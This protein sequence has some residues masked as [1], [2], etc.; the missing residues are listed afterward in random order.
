M[1]IAIVSNPQIKQ[2]KELGNIVLEDF[3]KKGIDS[4]LIDIDNLKLGY[5]FVLVIGGDGTV[6]K[7]ARFYSVTSTPIM[8]VNL[9]RLGFLSLVSR[10]SINQLADIIQNGEYNI[11][12]RIMLEYEGGSERIKAL[13]DFVIKGGSYNR[14]SKFNLFINEK[15]I[16]DCIADGL[17]ISTPTGSTA[18]GLSAGGPVLAPCLNCMVIVPI[19]A[20][21]MNVRPLV[22]PD[23]EKISVKSNNLILS[24]D[25]QECVSKLNDISI[26][27]SKHCA[28]LAFPKNEFFYSVLKS[29]LYWGV[30][31][32][33]E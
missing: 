6:L 7:T 21:T 20:H 12:E 29:K 4:E 26:V 13:N 8:G 24:A 32:V 14:T 10:K 30:S 31:A 15:H 3:Q 22:I 1:K 17:I 23:T 33:S 2:S 11:E 28:R 16:F 27:K 18:Y 25:G 5:D 19:C 9:G